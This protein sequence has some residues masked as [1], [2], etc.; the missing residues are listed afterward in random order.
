[1]LSVIIATDNALKESYKEL[2]NSEKEILYNFKESTEKNSEEYKKIITEFVKHTEE[3]SRNLISVMQK[4]DINMN[5]YYSI[6]TNETFEASD[7]LFKLETQLSLLGEK[8]IERQE[9]FFNKL[10]TGLQVQNNS[11]SS[12]MVSSGLSSER[13]LQKLLTQ[14]NI[15]QIY[16]EN[17]L[18]EILK[19]LRRE[20]LLKTNSG[21]LFENFKAK[22]KKNS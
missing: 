13:E 6:T 12:S 1:M 3:I 5:K 4:L 8:W 19:D 15:N 16:F 20:S 17:I 7:S 2:A 11:T 14:I 9:K 22:F 18:K 21:S 10:E